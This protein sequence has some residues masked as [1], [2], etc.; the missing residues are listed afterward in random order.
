MKIAWAVAIRGSLVGIAVAA[1]GDAALAQSTQAQRDGAWVARL[2]RTTPCIA[3]LPVL[4][5]PSEISAKTACVLAS[6]AFRTVAAG[7][8]TSLGVAVRDTA[9]VK[10]I[11][12]SA[13]HF[14]GLNGSPDAILWIVYMQFL[15]R[16]PDLAFAFD[17]VKH[18]MSTGISEHGVSK[19]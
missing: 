9:W 3:R 4:V 19:P 1:Y 13:Q 2:A 18:S 15:T 11:V 14:R 17:R 6:K 8:A 16:S 5:R 7:K 12:I 10:S